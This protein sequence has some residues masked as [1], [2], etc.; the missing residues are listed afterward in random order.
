M[1]LGNEPI[2]RRTVLRGLGVAIALP[3]LDAMRPARALAATGEAATS[4][5]VRMACLFFPN[6][7][8][9]HHWTP[10]ATGRDF[11]LTEILAPLGDLRREV[12]VLSQLWNAATNTGDGHYVKTAGWLT[13][14]TIRKTTG[15]ELDA[16]GVSLDQLVARRIG[17]LTAL[18]SLELGIEP[19]TTGVD[20]NVGY[21]R[22]YGSHISW[23]TPTTPVA[24]EIRPRLA[25]DRLFR[26]D[27]DRGARRSDEDESV[28]DLAL[29]D[30]RRLRGEVGH[31]DRLKLDEYL[32]SIRAVEKRIAFDRKKRNE[33]SRGDAAVEKAIRALGDRIDLYE[34]PGQVS[35]RRIDHTE[36]V[37]I[38]LDLMVLAFWSDSTRTS[39]FMFGNSVSGKNFSFLDGV[40]GGHHQISHHENDPTKLEEYKRINIWHVEQLAYLLRRMQEIREG[41]A[42]LLDRSM[43][44]F[45][46]GLRD[47]NR[48]DPHDLPVVLAGRAGGTIEPGRHIACSKNSRL[49]D[50]YLSMARRMGVAAERFGDSESELPSLAG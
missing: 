33:E 46:S 41:E 26:V 39:T 47:G 29:D 34:D 17:H 27:P 7:V 38:M 13:G 50:L 36:H 25:F 1:I 14:T 24:R 6:G 45:G 5:P 16:G 9:P 4:P 32:D 10:A 20:S 31:R 48:H 23:S 49:C 37:R 35:E 19:V 18:P 28:L 44:L 2:P 12:L 30:A 8:N 22:L 3:F 42:T 15:S 40:K 11:E 21:T 43:V